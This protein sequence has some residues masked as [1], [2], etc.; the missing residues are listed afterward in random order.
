VLDLDNTLICSVPLEQYNKTNVRLRLNQ[1]AREAGVHSKR[2]YM[3]GLFMVY[4]RPGL[5]EFLESVF[6]HFNVVIFSMASLSYAWWVIRKFILGSTPQIVSRRR[7]HILAVLSEPQCAL[8]QQYASKKSST[9]GSPKYLEWLFREH[10]ELKID[11]KRTWFLDDLE[12][13][14]KANPIQAIYTPAFDVLKKDSGSDTFLWNVRDE[15]KQKH[16]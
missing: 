11:P 13:V 14:R 10:P 9:N 6:E 8:S 4:A 2:A 1:Y 16:Q 7:K 15:L 12:V 3:H 5:D